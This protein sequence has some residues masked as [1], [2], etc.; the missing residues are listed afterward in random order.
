MTGGKLTSFAAAVSGCIKMKSSVIA[1]SL[2]QYAS[3]IFGILIF[4]AIAFLS[5]F[6]KLGSLEV[7]I[8]IVFWALATITT[9]LIKIK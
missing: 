8:Y 4:S 2:F 1:A 6:Q 3:I 9:S 7:L 5:G